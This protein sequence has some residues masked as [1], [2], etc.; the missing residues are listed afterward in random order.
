MTF[1]SAST[2]RFIMCSSPVTEGVS[3]RRDWSIHG[4]PPS[5]T[6]L[7][8]SRS[9]PLHPISV[10][11]LV[12]SFSVHSVN[13]LH[14]YMPTHVCAL[15]WP[16]PAEFNQCNCIQPR[17]TTC[18]QPTS[19]ISTVPWEFLKVP[20]AFRL[21]AAFH[22]LSLRMLLR[23]LLGLEIFTS[24]C[25][26]RCGGPFAVVARSLQNL[27]YTRFMDVDFSVYIKHNLI[28]TSICNSCPVQSG[29]D[30]QS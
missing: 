1:S 26:F 27:F 25:I 6:G 7:L 13:A 19:R 21:S 17:A 23:A 29:L 2:V 14:A 20:C 5:V 16:Y 30:Y 28:E 22:T 18:I 8:H 9:V 4:V 10:N 12:Y 3:P 11:G 24:F 15:R